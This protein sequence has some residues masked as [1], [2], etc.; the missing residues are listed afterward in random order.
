MSTAF[1][2]VGDAVMSEDLDT[3]ISRLV[4]HYLDHIQPVID[5]MAAADCHLFDG[6]DPAALPAECSEQSEHDLKRMEAFLRFRRCVAGAV[7]DWCRSQGLPERR[8]YQALS[9]AAATAQEGKETN[10]TILL[11]LLAA[12]EDFGTFAGYMAGEAESRRALRA[13]PPPWQ[14]GYAAG[15]GS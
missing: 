1:S 3:A 8:L 6:L 2:A 13:S 5:E 10:G 15:Q 11:E 12:A 4:S 14:Q 7:D 9:Q